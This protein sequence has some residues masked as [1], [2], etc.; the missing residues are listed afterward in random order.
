MGP[1]GL[2]AACDDAS[3]FPVPVPRPRPRPR[4]CP[5]VVFSRLS[6]SLLPLGIEHERHPVEPDAFAHPRA[7]RRVEERDVLPPRD[8]AKEVFPRVVVQRGVCPR[9]DP[10][11]QFPHGPREEAV[12]A[13]ARHGPPRD[14]EGT[15]E[16]VWGIER[17]VHVVVVVAALAGAS[18]ASEE[19]AEGGDVVRPGGLDVSET[20]GGAAL[21]AN[22]GVADDARKATVRSDVAEP[23]RPGIGQALDERGAIAREELVHEVRFGRDADPGNL[24][25]RAGRDGGCLQR[26][27]S[28]GLPDERERAR[29][30]ARETPVPRRALRRPVP[31]EPRPRS[32]GGSREGCRHR[33]TPSGRGGGEGQRH[34]EHETHEHTAQHVRSG[35][36]RDPARRGTP[37]GGRVRVTPHAASALPKMTSSAR[38]DVDR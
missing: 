30:L 15:R 12:L 2:P 1:V 10:H 19:F 32:C 5:D 33:G 9:T 7:L 18:A 36:V 37:R 29:V 11:E 8:D 16:L 38:R 14:I 6:R 27:G 13:E 35:V 22:L 34:P 20:T 25:E 4:P 3:R 28:P 17:E 26:G 24:R 23:G 21:D 31:V